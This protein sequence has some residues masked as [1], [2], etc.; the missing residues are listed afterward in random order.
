MKMFIDIFSGATVASD[1]YPHV[2]CFGGAAIKFTAKF[3]TK[4]NDYAGLP[5]G[6][7]DEEGGNEP[8]GETVIDMVDTYNLHTIEGYTVKEWL[9]MIKPTMGHIMKVVKEKGELDEEQTKA[10]K[11]GCVEFVNFIKGKF[12]DIQMYQGEIGEYGGE[13]QWFGYAISENQDEPLELTF[14]FF[15]DAL[16]EEKY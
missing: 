4:T 5:P 2:V 9:A 11:K 8:D 15:K 14:Y 16:K 10:Y 3:V 12:T 1:A 6:E 7:G 13:E